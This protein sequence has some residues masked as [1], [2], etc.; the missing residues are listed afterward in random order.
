M[1][2]SIRCFISSEMAAGL[3][4]RLSS[5]SSLIPFAADT[6]ART[7]PKVFAI[8]PTTFLAFAS[9]KALREK[10]A[11]DKSGTTHNVS[12][13]FITNSRTCPTCLGNLCCSPPAICSCSLSML[14]TGMSL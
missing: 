9:S 4:L 2:A 5:A 8:V 6:R 7:V 11:A 1:A 13:C 10:T 3:R 12:G 14:T